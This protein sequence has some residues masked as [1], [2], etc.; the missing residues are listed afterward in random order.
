MLNV[1][2]LAPV[3]QTLFTDRADQLARDTGFIR[4]A[5][6]FSGAPFLQA[7][8]HGLLRRPQ[9]PLEDLALPLGISR[10]ALDQRWTP[11]AA[12]F[13]RQALLE[14]VGHALQ[15]RPEVFP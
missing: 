8:V 9:A 7:L 11:Q 3:L 15:A 4:R 1:A 12:R 13:C 14:A 2:T 6:A 10:Q 5:R